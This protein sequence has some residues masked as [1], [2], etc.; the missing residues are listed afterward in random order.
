MRAYVFV[1]VSVRP[2]VRV[3]KSLVAINHGLVYLSILRP[4]PVGVLSVGT[5][6]DGWVDSGI[7][8]NAGSGA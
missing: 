3:R 6:I 1:C 8:D 7:G 5:V 4:S 2:C